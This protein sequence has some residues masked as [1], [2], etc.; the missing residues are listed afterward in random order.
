MFAAATLRP[1]P[2]TRL[3]SISV[4]GI[5]QNGGALQGVRGR[6]KHFFGGEVRMMNISK[7][8]SDAR[9]SGFCH[10]VACDRWQ[11]T[12]ARNNHSKLALLRNQLGSVT[13]F[14]SFFG[15]GPSKKPSPNNRVAQGAGLL[16]GA[17]LLF[18]KTKYLLAALKF[19]KLA[20]LG[21]M[22]LTIGTYSVF[23]GW[24]YAVGMVGLIAV[25]EAG[26]AI[27]L[28]L[29]GI[30][31]SP[32]VFVPFMGAVIVTKQ[33]PRDA[34]EDAVIAYGGPALGSLGAGVVA[35]G[36]HMTQ[37]QL[38]YALADFGFMINLFNLLPLGSL[39]GGRIAGAISPY[40]GVVGLGI[41][42]TLAYTGAVANPIF[43]I[44]LFSGAY[45]T[46]MRFYDT[47]RLPPNY[48][49]ISFPKRA[50]I[51]L[52]YFGLIVALIAAMDQ[53]RRYRK[54]PEVLMREREVEKTFDMRY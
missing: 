2:I 40:A 49:K 30:P 24:P 3:F 42:G 38:L 53:N 4:V 19:T 50:G 39:D 35:I 27:V 12:S 47:S 32:A 44:V 11:L 18:G 16:G 48:Y 21:S 23:F 54:P 52:G 29:K 37:S 1:S 26:H 51:T 43:Y 33:L 5:S 14:S 28:H 13:H 34:W 22:V 46:F 25:H 17:M 6:G 9:H 7:R 15:G 45:E 41:G 8:F 20:S 10:R 36:A 31:F